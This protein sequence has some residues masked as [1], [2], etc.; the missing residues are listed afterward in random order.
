M[1]PAKATIPSLIVLTDQING[2]QTD[3]QTGRTDGQKCKNMTHSKFKRKK[4]SGVLGLS[5]VLFRVDDE[6]INE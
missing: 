5:C 4:S 6:F 3:R 1:R 2:R